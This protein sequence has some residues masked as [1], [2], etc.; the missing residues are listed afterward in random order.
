MTPP[1]PPRTH[2][3]HTWHTLMLDTNTPIWVDIVD[4]RGRVE[5]V[6]VAGAVLHGGYNCQPYHPCGRRVQHPPPPPHP[7]PAPATGIRIKNTDYFRYGK[8]IDGGGG[9]RGGGRRGNRAWPGLAVV[10]R[11]R[12]CWQPVASQPSDSKSAYNDVPVA[13]LL[14]SCDDSGRWGSERGQ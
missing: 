14:Q 12:T 8:S 10:K 6:G 11:R 2:S 9:G 5:A 7:L 3:T 4:Q 13:S 1:P